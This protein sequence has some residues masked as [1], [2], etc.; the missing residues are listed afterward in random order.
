MPPI[1]LFAQLKNS[2]IGKRL[3]RGTIWSVLATIAFRGLNTLAMIFMARILGK[4]QFGEIGIIQSN[5]NMFQTLAGF[6]LGWTA[7]K[8]VAQYKTLD[9]AKTGRILAFVSTFAIV[10][11]GV[12]SC[13]YYC[14]APWIA[15]DIL[16]APHLSSALQYSSFLLLIGSLSGTQNG[17]L[18]GFEAFKSIAKINV[19]SGIMNLCAVVSGGFFFGV[20]GVV[21]GLLVGQSVNWLM[22]SFC[23]RKESAERG[24]VQSRRGCLAEKEVLWKFGLPVILGGLIFQCGTWATSVLL[25]NQPG[26]YAEMG[27][28]NAAN[29]W[30]ILLLFLPRVL[31]QAAIPVLSEQLALGQTEK[32]KKILFSTIVFNSLVVFSVVL[33]ASLLSPLIMR[34]YG[35][36]FSG[37]WMTLVFILFAAGISAVQT[38]SANVL[39]SSDKMWGVTVMN[40][41]WAL[42]FVCLSFFLIRWGSAGVAFSRMIAY[43][44]YAAISLT[45]SLWIIKLGS[46][47]K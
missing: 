39:T 44:A 34:L 40:I 2:P 3:I 4:E 23:V 13:L 6:G 41:V 11:G 5:L 26:G 47:S 8:Y 37:D 31:G 19:L 12:L 33:P 25:V 15:K 18:V 20:E 21:F 10:S 36:D 7:T 9:Q 14:A 1:N 43:L 27:I 29:Q 28:Y 46:Q 38:P 32:V 24:I 17:I 45:F 30:F 22:Y 16:A 42:I 35:K